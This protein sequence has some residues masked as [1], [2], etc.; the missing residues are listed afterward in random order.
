MPGWAW[1]GI[2]ALAGLSAAAAW[3]IWF[4]KDFYR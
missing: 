4:L 3:L 2:G 1:F